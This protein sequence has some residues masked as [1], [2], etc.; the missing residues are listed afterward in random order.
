MGGV[1]ARVLWA[2]AYL[3][4]VAEP[5]SIPLWE[6]V[7]AQGPVE[8]VE[9]IRAGDIDPPVLRA[10]GARRDVVDP[11]QDLAA[12]ARHGI[13]VVVPESDDWPHFAFASLEHAARRRL[14]TF[15]T[16]DTSHADH[17][18]PIPPLA[19]WTSGS[20][21]LREV[22]TR[23]AGIVGSRAATAYGERVATELAFDLARK[24]VVV[25]SGGA[26]GIDAAAHRGAL[27]G[28]GATVIV[29]AGGLDHAYP[30][31]H[32]RLFDEVRESGLL[33]SESPP[34]SAPR[35]RRFLTRNRLIAALSTGVVVVEAARRSGALNT[36]SHCRRIGRP[37]MAVPGPVTSAASSG[38]HDLLADPRRDVQL[39][40]NALDVAAIVAGFD[41]GLVDG[42]D[43]GLDAGDGCAG[44]A[45]GAR[46]AEGT[47]RRRSL[48]D[49]LSADA[50]QVVDAFPARA[51]LSVDDL[52][53]RAGMSVLE[54]IRTLPALELSGLIESGADGYRLSRATGSRGKPG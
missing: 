52:S 15:H 48:M 54:V 3:S 40:T 45:D 10:V 47:D 28:G 39:V 37:L 32:G 23:S 30:P 31:S 51:S 1:T 4:R 25:V 43:G 46:P 6:F 12:A 44:P 2:R 18:E 26:Y 8:A 17:G 5:A 11:D 34:G 24:D 20:L 27:R 42:S 41:S 33:I 50:R 38:C 7:E 22:G 29:S 21:S 36:A 14:D 9:R 19:L 49:A 13:N 16:G 35:R 53:V